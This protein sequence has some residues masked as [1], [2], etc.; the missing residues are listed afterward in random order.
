MIS[1]E[2]QLLVDHGRTANDVADSTAR[3]LATSLATMA[4]LELIRTRQ[5]SFSTTRLTQYGCTS[6]SLS[7]YISGMMEEF[8]LLKR[9]RGISSLF[10]GFASTSWL[11][12]DVH[13]SA[14]YLLFFERF[15]NH[16]LLHHRI[17][18]W[19]DGVSVGD[20]IMK[21]WWNNLLVLRQC[22]HL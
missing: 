9:T 8:K 5:I 19:D 12:R 18:C 21:G 1:T 2:Q 22:M 13:L 4:P 6:T 3:L 14:F 11:W 15:C 20:I 16:F 10:A 17:H 7:V